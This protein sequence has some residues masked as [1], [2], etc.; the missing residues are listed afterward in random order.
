[1]RM[2]E[3]KS[4]DVACQINA[5]HT[6]VAAIATGVA[7]RDRAECYADLV[8]SAGLRSSAVHR[9]YYYKEGFSPLLPDRLVDSLG[10]AGTGVVLDPFLGVGTTPV[11]LRSR[12]DVTSVLGSEYSPFAHFVATTKVAATQVDPKRLRRCA[13]ASQFQGGRSHADHPATDEP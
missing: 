6:S 12:P 4:G 3:E 11:A 9:W 13:S 5:L 7:V 1:M 10:T 8:G 2:T